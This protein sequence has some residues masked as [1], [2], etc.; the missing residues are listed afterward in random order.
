MPI[1]G[2][3]FGYAAGASPGGTWTE[4]TDLMDLPSPPMLVADDLEQTTHGSGGVKEYKTGLSDVPNI[5]AKMRYLMDAAQVGLITAQSAKTE[6]WFRCEIPDEDNETQYFAWEMQGFV[7]KA[8]PVTP[9][10]GVWTFELEAK[11]SDNYTF[12]STPYASQI[13]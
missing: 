3:K 13:P 5:T 2:V 9:I 10:G 7:K 4:L 11:Y 8:A 1:Q 12:Y 6:L